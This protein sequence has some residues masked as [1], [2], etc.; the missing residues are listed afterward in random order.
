M[1][2]L[3]TPG[4]AIYID[5]GNGD[6][7][8]PAAFVSQKAGRV[9]IR[10]PSGRQLCRPRRLIRT[11][12]ELEAPPVRRPRKPRPDA[13]PPRRKTSSSCPRG[14]SHGKHCP[15]LPEVAC[16]PAAP[17]PHLPGTLERMAVYAARA[18]RR[19]SLFHPR[20]GRMVE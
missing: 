15:P 11:A 7:W 20:D 2:T 13:K 5:P 19:L 9:W 4:Q 10:L 18:E 12:A 17:T 16:D 3:L 14:H 8:Q 1:P 6:G